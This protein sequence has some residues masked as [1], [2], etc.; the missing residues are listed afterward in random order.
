M[1]RTSSTTMPSL[2]LLRLRSPPRGERKNRAWDL[3]LKILPT[4]GVQTPCRG[5]SLARF[6]GNFHHFWEYCGR[7]ILKFGDIHSR[8]SGVMAV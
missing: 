7:L 6:L 2:V 8:G 1:V 3:K 5:V 4:L